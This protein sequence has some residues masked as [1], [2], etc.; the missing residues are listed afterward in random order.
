MNM[1][2]DYMDLEPPPP[3][4]ERMRLERLLGPAVAVAGP[5]RIKLQPFWE[6]SPDEW[7]GLAEAQFELAGVV[8]DRVKFNNVLSVLPEHLV[9]SINDLLRPPSPPDAYA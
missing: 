4:V 6:A 5:P 2:D 9:R 1:N 8:A 7:F 3:G